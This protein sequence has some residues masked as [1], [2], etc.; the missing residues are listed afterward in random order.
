MS[1][2]TKSDTVKSLLLFRETLKLP[3]DPCNHEV[4]KVN[5]SFLLPLMYCS[6]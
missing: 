1:P 6:K 4:N 2:C 3:Y 5:V